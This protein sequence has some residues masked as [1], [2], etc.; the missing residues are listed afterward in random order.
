[1]LSLWDVFED[2]GAEDVGSGVDQVARCCSGWGFFDESCYAV[3]FCQF[4]DSVSA[5]VLHFVEGYGCGA[6]VFFV[7]F[8]HL[9]VVYV[10]E[11]VAV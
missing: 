9:C 6:V 8:E 5:W 4:C 3:V 7:L 11:Y 10:G 2:F 1:M